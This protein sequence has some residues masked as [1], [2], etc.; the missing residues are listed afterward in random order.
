MPILSD[1]KIPNESSAGVVFYEEGQ[2]WCVPWTESGDVGNGWPHE[3]VEHGWAEVD[4]IDELDGGNGLSWWYLELT[5]RVRHGCG[6]N[7]DDNG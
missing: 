1:S 2:R 6:V 5:V 3:A 7:D 4:G